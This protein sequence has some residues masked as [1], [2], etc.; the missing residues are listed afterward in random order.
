MELKKVT[1]RRYL[2]WF[3]TTPTMLISTIIFMEYSKQKEQNKTINFWEFL[4]DHK[5]NIYKII[6][7]NYGMLIFGLLGELEYYNKYLMI[8]I[9]FIFFYYL[10]RF[11]YIRICEIFKNIYKIIFIF[12]LLYG[13]YMGLRQY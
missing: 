10:F 11:I 2:D 13:D 12:W 6:L 7:L 3:I 1:S 4:K 5:N 9:G 8:F